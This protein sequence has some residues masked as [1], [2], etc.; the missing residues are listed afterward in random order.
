M[1]WGH[2]E[3]KGL[4]KTTIKDFWQW[5]YS[6][7]LINKNRSDLGLFLTANALQ[8]TKMPRIDWGNVELRYRNK[9]IAVKTSGYIQNW[10]QKRPKRVLF[11]IPPKKGIDAPTEDSITFRNRE[12]EIYIFCLH[13]EK[14]VSKVDVL[15]LEQWRFY[16]V[17]TASLDLDFREKKKIGIQP[18]NKLATPVHQSKIKAIVDDLIDYELTE[19]MV[20]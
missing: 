10:R 4:D 7:L 8:L 13:T 18:L 16:I 3:I 19:R 6:D 1:F 15:N 5:T 11:D 17:R 20:L 14:D 9:K 12:A 2:E